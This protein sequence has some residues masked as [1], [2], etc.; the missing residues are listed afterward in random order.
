MAIEKKDLNTINDIQ[1]KATNNR[2]F[3]QDTRSIIFWT[4]EFSFNPTFITQP[5]DVLELGVSGLD[6][7]HNFYKLVASAYSQDY[8]PLVVVVYGDNVSADFTNLINTYKDNENAFEVTN[9]VTNIEVV[10]NKTL[11]DSAIEYAKTDK[12]I[13]MSFGIEFSK[14][15]SVQDIVT[16]QT[17]ANANDVSLIVEGAK[18]TALGNWLT[19]AIWGGNIG[20]KE[21]G[22]YTVHPLE[23]KGFV[24]E[25][26]TKT[27]QKAMWDAGLNYLSKPTRGYMHVV[28]GMN[29]DNKTFI[30]LNLI[31]IW[32]TDQLKK[33]ISIT[34]ITMDKLP[35]FGAGK[36][37]LTGIISEVCREGASKGMFLTDNSGDYLGVIIQ[38]DNNGNKLQIKLGHLIVDT[39]TQ[40]NMR[41]GKL[42]FDLKLT[43]ENGVRFVELRGEVTTDG[44]LLLS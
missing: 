44:E 1:I 32:L 26:F 4:N 15:T 28:N 43:Y 31:R 23:I 16:L 17:T 9:W 19:G 36:N 3:F 27:E 25:T 11:F 13:Q 18:N 6:V 37:I 14:F 34:Q 29:T 20:A 38:T 41:E 2:T 42:S 39:I 24:Q 33:R 10:A 35:L 8:T 22:S 12:E 21:L 7:D 5:S 30:E 40:D